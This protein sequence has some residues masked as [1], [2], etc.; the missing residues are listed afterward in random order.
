V[1]VLAS[2]TK[3]VGFVKSISLHAMLFAWSRHF[4]AAPARGP[5]TEKQI[6][7][8]STP[9]ALA[10]HRPIHTT[11]FVKEENLK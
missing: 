6:K 5:V 2:C 8:V 3:N 11:Y 1:L 7:A 4:Y 9:D 10:L